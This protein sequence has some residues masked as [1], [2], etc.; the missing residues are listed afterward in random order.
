[1]LTAYVAMQRG[2]DAAFAFEQEA[3]FWYLCGIDSP[4]WWLIVDGTRGKSWLVAPDVDGVHQTFEGSLPHDEA[5][6]ISGAND[7][8]SHDDALK[9]LR[10]L[11]K[12][13][14]VAYTLGEHPHREHFNFV[15]NPA[16]KKLSNVLERMFSSVQDC[17][18]DMAQLR[19][20]K[21]P[22]EI[23]A[24]K[25]AIRLT[26][27]TFDIVK[28]KLPTLH[29]EYEVEAEFDYHF[30]KHGSHHGYDPIVAGGKNACTLHYMKNNA[31][32][33][34]GSLLLL[35]IGAIYGGYCADISRTFAI[36]QPT[37]RQLEVYASVERAH[38]E[39][40]T[41]LRPG[42]LIAEYSQKVDDIMKRALI[43]IGLLKQLDD[44]STYRRY[45]PHA[46]SHGLG[47]DVHDSLG[48]PRFFEP[49]MVLTVEPGIYIPDEAIG[50]RI[51]DDIL[52]TAD[53][54]ENLSTGLSTGLV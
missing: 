4:D 25:K 37:K 38:K 23:V 51:E 50:V 5:L 1:V 54:N 48:S 26:C 49:G 16:Q 43:D 20:I 47:V 45:F 9:L 12:K 44:D 22:E 6:K 27:D 46:I 2:N 14:S 41:L 42:L 36:G 3:N 7:V 10:E 11:A 52:I 18:K 39:I 24:M 33:K 53:G 21:Q 31:T 15:E 29:Y 35:D 34:K 28:Q 13:H 8:I 32:L 19:A 30:K 17:R 40:I